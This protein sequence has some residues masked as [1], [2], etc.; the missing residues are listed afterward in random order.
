MAACVALGV[1]LNVVQ[2]EQTESAILALVGSG[3]GA[4]L[5]NSANL[6]RRPASVKFLRL[7]DLPLAMPLVFAYRRDNRSPLL[8]RF[9]ETVHKTLADSHVSDAL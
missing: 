8:H 9:L 7:T 3:I 5:V 4:A 6:S 1:S 2:E